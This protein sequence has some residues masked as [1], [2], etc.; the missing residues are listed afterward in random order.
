MSNFGDFVI[1]FLKAFLVPL[2]EIIK[3]IFFG[4]VDMFNVVNY[5]NI[6]AFYCAGNGAL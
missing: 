6:F 5:Y 2:W 4:F 1:D 3:G